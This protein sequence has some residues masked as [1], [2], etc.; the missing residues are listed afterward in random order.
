MTAYSRTLTALEVTGKAGM[1]L[2][3]DAV[4]CCRMCA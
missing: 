3:A 2:P 4:V 1:M